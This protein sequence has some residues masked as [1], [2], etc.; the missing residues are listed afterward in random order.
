MAFQLG[1][2]FE[3]SIDESEIDNDILDKE[4]FQRFC[5]AIKKGQL[6]DT[7]L[8]KL[9]RLLPKEGRNEFYREVMDQK[10]LVYQLKDEVFDQN[11]TLRED[12]SPQ[13]VTAMVGAINNFVSFYIKNLDKIEENRTLY[14]IEA[15]VIA[16]VK[17][18]GNDAK[19]EFLKTLNAEFG[20][21]SE[22]L[23]I[24]K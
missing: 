1:D 2:V 6:S 4:T 19:V 11:S 3:E 18:L 17:T 14:G 5:S 12:A 9:N 7:M 13:Q 10:D 22:D 23:G 21:T 8:V 24:E 15:A 16:A 20:R